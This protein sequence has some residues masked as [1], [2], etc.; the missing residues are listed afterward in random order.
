MQYFVQHN[1]LRTPRIN[2][3]KYDQWLHGGPTLPFLTQGGVRRGV[4]TGAKLQKA[5]TEIQVDRLVTIH[6]IHP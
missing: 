6:S 4:A 3:T 2:I 5:M 1:R